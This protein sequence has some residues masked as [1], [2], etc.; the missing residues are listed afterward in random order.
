MP[1]LD[2]EFIVIARVQQKILKILESDLNR[3]LFTLVSTIITNIIKNPGEE[4]YRK[5]KKQN[6]KFKQLLDTIPE[7]IEILEYAGFKQVRRSFS[8]SQLFILFRMIPLFSSQI[9]VIWVNCNPLCS[10]LIAV[11]MLRFVHFFFSHF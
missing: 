4:K 9:R 10:L 1:A 8:L 11:S 3:Q 5:I 6:P 7:T 2:P